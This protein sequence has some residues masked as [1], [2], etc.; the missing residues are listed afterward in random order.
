MSTYY[1]HFTNRR[2]HPV[3]LYRIKLQS[4]GLQSN[5]SNQRNHL[6]TKCFILCSV[7]SV[8]ANIAVAEH[9]AVLPEHLDDRGA[10]KPRLTPH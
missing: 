7:F 10:N 8:S 2:K 3:F 5:G 6:K 4:N 9:S 1:R